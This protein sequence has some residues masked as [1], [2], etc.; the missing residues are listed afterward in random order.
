MVVLNQ[1]TGESFLIPGAPTA[2]IKTRLQ[3]QKALLAAYIEEADSFLKIPKDDPT[4]PA[5]F[6]E[7]LGLHTVFLNGADE[8]VKLLRDYSRSKMADTLKWEIAIALVMGT[9]TILMTRQLLLANRHIN[10]EMKERIHA[11]EELRK[12][13][14]RYDI[15]V[16]GSN[17]GLWDSPHA[18]AHLCL[19][20]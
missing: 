20:G 11:E 2:E 13:E 14:E 19:L 4:W 7:L 12:S 3:S 16:R 9:F 6:Q 18:C 15:A 1:G 8:T 5:K 10:A 17:D